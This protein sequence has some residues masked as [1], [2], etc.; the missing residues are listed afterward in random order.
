MA[1]NDQGRLTKNE[2][3]QQ[4][5]EKARQ[6]R[7]KE[8]ARE[9]RNRLLLQGGIVLGVL[10]IVVVVGLVIA[11]A[12]KPAGPGPANMASGGVVFEQDLQV[13]DTPALESGEKRVEADAVFDQKPLRV[14]VFSDYMCPACGS[15]E[16]QYGDMLEQYTGSG[17]ISLEVYPITFLDAQSA[18]SKYSSR[19]SN[20]FGCVVEQQPEKAY[21]FHT[22]LFEPGVQ[23]QEGTSGLTDQELVDAAVEAGVEKTSEFTSCVRDKRFIPFFQGNTKQAIEQGVLGLA[24]GAQLLANPQTG[25]MQPE[26]E[27]QRLVSAPLVLVNGQQW[28]SQEDGDLEAYILKQLQNL[29]ADEAEDDTADS[30]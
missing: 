17:D 14:E 29:D 19:A 1:G 6:A 24:P 7:E 9:K 25:E 8:R 12:L 26:G 23:P 4:A 28:N 18:G 2:R 5:R 20:A 30:E 3:R 27:P 13:Q 16:Q 15:F 10:A 22:H 11:N 21:A